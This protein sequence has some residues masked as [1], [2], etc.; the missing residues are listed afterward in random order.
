MSEP[1]CK[2]THDYASH[3]QDETH[4]DTEPCWAGAVVGDHCTCRDY[5]PKEIK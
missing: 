5:Q 1:K 2:C 3:A 4:K